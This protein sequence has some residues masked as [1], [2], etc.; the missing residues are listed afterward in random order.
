MEINTGK[1][2]GGQILKQGQSPEKNG[3]TTRD[4][5]S[6]EDGTEEDGEHT[7]YNTHNR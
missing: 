6:Q 4:N 3:A 1:T 2:S 7:R 5:I